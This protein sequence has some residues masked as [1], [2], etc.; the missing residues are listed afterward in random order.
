[1]IAAASF[2]VIA[3]FVGQKLF[4][5]FPRRVV[6]TNEDLLRLAVIVLGISVFSSFLGIWRAMRVEPN[7]SLMG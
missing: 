5:Y 2:G 4:P 6:L 3:Y 7:E 1:M